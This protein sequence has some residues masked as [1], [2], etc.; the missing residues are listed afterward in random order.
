MTRK[1]SRYHIR[2]EH[3]IFKEAETTALIDV[4]TGNMPEPPES[5]EADSELRVGTWVD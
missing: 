4:K 3:W 1:E 2:L 5:M